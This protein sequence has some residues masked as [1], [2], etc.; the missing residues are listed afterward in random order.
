MINLSKTNETRDVSARL[1]YGKRRNCYCN[2][3]PA[4]I[5]FRLM[6]EEYDARLQAAS[7]SESVYKNKLLLLEERFA[8]IGTQLEKTE[9]KLKECMSNLHNMDEVNFAHTIG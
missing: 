8:S 7:K 3:D 1:L 6:K 4:E 9:E 2:S 5:A